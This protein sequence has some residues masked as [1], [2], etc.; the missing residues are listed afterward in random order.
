MNEYVP[1]LVTLL[2]ALFGAGGLWKLMDWGRRNSMAAQMQGITA[3]ATALVNELQEELVAARRTAVDAQAKVADLDR[4]VT[5]LAADV[6]RLVMWIHLPGQT[7]DQLRQWVPPRP[8]P[9]N[10][11]T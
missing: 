2:A 5:R 1:H 9:P 7:L 11:R 8:P 6:E 3:N 4:S 10:G